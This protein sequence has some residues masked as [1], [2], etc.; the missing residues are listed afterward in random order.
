MDSYDKANELIELFS[1][2]TT[3]IYS[4]NSIPNLLHADKTKDSAIEDAILHVKEL[5]K[6]LQLCNC[7]V[8]SITYLTDV[9]TQ[10]QKRKTNGR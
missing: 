9:I 1:T 8:Y 5:I 4:E 10:L 6:T 3:V 7:G 2:K